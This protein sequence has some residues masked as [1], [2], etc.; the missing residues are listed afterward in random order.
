MGRLGLDVAASSGESAGMKIVFGLAALSAALLACSGA[1][2]PPREVMAASSA[3]AAEL[4]A[5]S[6]DAAAEHPEAPADDAAKKAADA[7]PPEGPAPG[8]LAKSPAPYAA[9]EVFEYLPNDCDERFYIDTGN[10]IGANVKSIQDIVEKVLMSEGGKREKARVETVIRLVRAENAS[11]VATW[12]EIAVCK[13]KGREV[14]AVG[15][16]PDH[17]I[18]VPVLVQKI[19]LALG[20]EP[21]KVVRKGEI[22]KLDVSDGETVAQPAPN[23]FLISADLARLDA[24]L[25]AKAGAAGFKAAKGQ[26]AYA[27]S[28]KA[29]FSLIEKAKNLEGRVVVHLAGG[30]AESLKKDPK[31]FTKGLE[32]MIGSMADELKGSSVE[33]I[34]E[35]LRAIRISV[36]GTDVTLTGSISRAVIEGALQKTTPQD[37]ENLSRIH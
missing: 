33:P 14:I 2:P 13:S 19:K 23:V 20:D 25:A 9:G 30:E 10:L 16:A 28:R 26:L 11:P 3:P 32:R 27:K 6:S 1:E 4:P 35:R 31:G 12:R 24:G 15:F 37:I 29:D 17:A 7:P 21:G 8:W 36:S 5:S 22:S 18:E 34:G